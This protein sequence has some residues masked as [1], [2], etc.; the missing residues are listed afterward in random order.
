LCF[1]LSSSSPEKLGPSLKVPGAK[2]QFVRKGL[3][4]KAKGRRMADSDEEEVSDEDEEMSDE[5]S[6]AASEEEE[7]EE[8]DEEERVGRGAMKRKS[9]ADSPE[10]STAD[11]KLYC[12]CQQPSYG[13]MVGCDNDNCPYEWFHLECVGM[14]KVPKGDWMCDECKAAQA[15]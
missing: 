14:K 9:A 3:L 2:E 13:D 8:Y 15:S 11:S 7:E 6:A 5:E 12:I 4:P 10:E 1:F